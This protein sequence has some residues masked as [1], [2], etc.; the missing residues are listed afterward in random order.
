MTTDRAT[1]LRLMLPLCAVGAPRLSACSGVTMFLTTDRNFATAYVLLS[2][3]LAMAALLAAMR[4][5][6]RGLGLAALLP[7][8]LLVLHPLWTVGASGDCGRT[9]ALGAWVMAGL[10]GAMLGLELWLARRRPEAG[11]TRAAI[12]TAL[13]LLL[14]A[15]AVWL[16]PWSLRPLPTQRVYVLSLHASEFAEVSQAQADFR[17]SHGRYAASLSELGH[18]E[19]QV[20]Q[21]GGFYFETTLDADSTGFALRVR[22]LDW[23]QRGTWSQFLLHSDG[24]IFAAPDPGTGDF[25]DN[26]GTPSAPAS[27]WAE[28]DWLTR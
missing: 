24:R 13:P 14:L 11:R 9:M 16:L 15:V 1:G 7:L 8:G 2:A 23:P 21:V 20:W 5:R 26:P 4:V 22:P 17:Q 12:L 10:F 27:P 28:T 3:T 18:A 25:V 19:R 6:R